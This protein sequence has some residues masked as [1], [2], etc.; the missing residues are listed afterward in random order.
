MSF[1]FFGLS[2]SDLVCGC[3]DAFCPCSFM[4]TGNFLLIFSTEI[5]FIEL[6]QCRKRFQD[7][8]IAAAALTSLFS[9]MFPSINAFALM[10]LFLPASIVLRNE[11]KRCKDA[12][13]VRKFCLIYNIQLYGMIYQ[14]WNWKKKKEELAFFSC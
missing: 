13:V 7:F 12:R 8:T 1:Q 10:L 11:L 6:I 2:Q 4:G 9:W 14:N 3:Q 5:M